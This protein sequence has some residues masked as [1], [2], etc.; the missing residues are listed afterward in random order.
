MYMWSQF[1]VDLDLVRTEFAS[2]YA[3]GKEFKLHHSTVRKWIDRPKDEPLTIDESKMMSI[4]KV[5][6]AIRRLTEE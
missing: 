1:K 4:R 2:D 6:N 3:M 5:A